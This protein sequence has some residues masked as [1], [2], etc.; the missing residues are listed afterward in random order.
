MTEIRFYHL[1]RS[2]LLQCLPSLLTKALAS[3]RKI[4]IKA[5]AA[6]LKTIDDS[7]WVY[8]ADAFLPHGL[9]ES[10]YAAQQPVCLTEKEENINGADMLVLTHGQEHNKIN[11]F[12]LCCD[13]ID[14]RDAQAIAAARTRWKSYK[15]QGFVVTYWQQTDQGWDKKNS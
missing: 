10:A 2:E 14:G 13:M 6:A 15:D 1:E 5:P 11:E 12:T 3:G 9:A 8:Q 4:L 7:L